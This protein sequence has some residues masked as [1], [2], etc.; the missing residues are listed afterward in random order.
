MKLN[1]E[2]EDQK[3][4]VKRTAD[5]KVS[6]D[7][8]FSRFLLSDQTLNALNRCGFKR[9]SPIQLKGVPLARCGLGNLIHHFKILTTRIYW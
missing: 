9:P 1:E 3:E 2:S 7:V 5:I 8:T 4:T 6:E